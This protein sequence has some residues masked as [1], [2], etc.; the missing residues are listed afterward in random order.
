MTMDSRLLSSVSFSE[1]LTDLLDELRGL[2]E[3]SLSLSF[4]GELWFGVIF[5]VFSSGNSV[6]VKLAVIYLLCSNEESYVAENMFSNAVRSLVRYLSSKNT[7]C[8]FT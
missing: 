3:N 2:E 6:S 7:S 5:K 8:E 1:T 4:E